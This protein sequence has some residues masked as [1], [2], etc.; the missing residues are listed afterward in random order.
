MESMCDKMGKGNHS[1]YGNCIF[2]FD[3]EID[4]PNYFGLKL[5]DHVPIDSETYLSKPNLI[6]RNPKNFIA[7]TFS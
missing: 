1:N 5:D 3:E 4:N 7:H 6:I 2:I